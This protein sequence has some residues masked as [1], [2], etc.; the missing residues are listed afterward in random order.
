MNE[1]NELPVD[2]A[3][4]LHL[5]EPGFRYFGLSSRRDGKWSTPH[6]YRPEVGRG[7]PRFRGRVL[8]LIDEE[9]FSVADNFAACAVL[10]IICTRW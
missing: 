6:T 9:T 3:P 1:V 10:P 4:P 8:C 2:L 7:E 5:M